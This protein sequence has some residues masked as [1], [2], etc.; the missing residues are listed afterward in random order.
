[1]GGRSPTVRNTT[2]TLIAGRYE[3]GELLGRGGMAEVYAGTDLRL[4]R[5]VAIKL[6]Q[7]SM[8]ARDDIRVRFEAEARAAA[9]I[10]QPHAVAVYD[11]GEHEG[12]PYIVMERLPGNTLADRIA[13]GPVLTEA[14]A[15]AFGRQVLGALDAAHH[16]GMVHRDVKPGNILLTGEGS[17]KISDF[18]IAKSLDVSADLTGTGQLIGTPAYLAPEQLGGDP[19]SPLSDLYALGVVLYE[20]LVG[21][22]PFEG[23]NAMVTARAVAVGD[24]VPLG[25]LRPDLD[26]ALVRAVER[27]MDPD[28]AARFPSASAMGAALVTPAVPTI[29]PEPGPVTAGPDAT[30][31]L[32][33]AAVAAAS[34]PTSPVAAGPPPPATPSAGPTVPP[35]TPSPRVRAVDPAHVAAAAAFGASA[36]ADVEP[37]GPPPPLAGRR[38]PSLG[39][40]LGLLAL[41]A[42]ALIVLLA[43]V[44]ARESTDDL[45]T[46]VS[47]SAATTPTTVAPTTTVTSPGA[48]LAGELRAAADRLGGGDGVAAADLAGGLRAVADQVERGEATA[49]ASAT[50]LL[51]NLAGWFQNG[52]LTPAAAVTAVQV[53]QKVPGL[54]AAGSAPAAAS[55]PPSAAATPEVFVAT[56]DALKDKPGKGKDKD[57]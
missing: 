22:K 10:L 19:A 39:L 26:D 48:A 18:G 20:G 38:R 30:E 57:D 46:D 29:V 9:A 36:P 2:P 51:V 41:A 37:A 53:L 15:R 21:R 17:A 7:E 5:P 25:T 12:V 43:Q 8:A 55:A 4:S 14:E 40:R 31:V 6:L 34:I 49:S 52:Q 42:V 11:S 35:T 1:M 27:A 16:V 23:D 28:P 56:N 50:G 44:F 45:V 33:L 47:R 3:V 32:D 13:T 24:H 54:A